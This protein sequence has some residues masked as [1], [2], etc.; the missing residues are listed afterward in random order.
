ME[1]RN[2]NQSQSRGGAIRKETH[3]DFRPKGGLECH[4]VLKNLKIFSG[5]SEFLI[6]STCNNLTVNVI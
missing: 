3:W 2:E 6:P 4:I 1:R 5:I